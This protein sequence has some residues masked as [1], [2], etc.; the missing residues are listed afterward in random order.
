MNQSEDLHQ[1][2]KLVKQRYSRT[3]DEYQK[4][5]AWLSYQ[6]MKVVREDPSIENAEA[7]V[8]AEQ[9]F[10]SHPN[11]KK[12]AISYSERVLEAVKSNNFNYDSRPSINYAG[13]E[14]NTPD[15]GYVYV[16]R[17]DTKPNQ[18]K[19]GYTTMEPKNEC[20]SIR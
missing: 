17:S 19:I 5:L 8:D 2:T 16:A 13:N 9:D 12:N 1:I 7:F 20:K 6:S 4:E 11:T 3:K 14:K 15:L 18:I 10:L